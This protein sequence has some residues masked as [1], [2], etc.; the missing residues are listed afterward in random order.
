[1]WYDF[2]PQGGNRFQHHLNRTYFFKH[3]LNKIRQE[4]DGEKRLDKLRELNEINKQLTSEFEQINEIG[5]L[6]DGVA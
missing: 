5:Y 6:P 3:V 1:M 2:I 4:I